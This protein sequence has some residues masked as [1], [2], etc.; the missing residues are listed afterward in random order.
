MRAYEPIGNPEGAGFPQRSFVG[1]STSRS[2]WATRP[3]AVIDLFD[4]S[5][6]RGRLRPSV[7]R[8]TPML[9]ER[10][11]RFVL[12]AIVALP[13]AANADNPARA[14]RLISTIS[15]PGNPLRGFDIGWVDAATETY[16]LAGRAEKAVDI[17]AAEHG[18]FPPRVGGL[19]RPPAP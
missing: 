5:A 15:V 11:A 12:F 3:A 7:R 19:P 17:L 14:P 9:A 18:T 4:K 16:Y 13:L 6:D 2:G 1:L 10:I 8:S